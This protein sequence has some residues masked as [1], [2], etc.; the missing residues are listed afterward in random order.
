MLGS[1]ISLDGT[2]RK[3]V[4][5]RGAGTKPL[6]GGSPTGLDGS[7]GGRFLSGGRPSVAVGGLELGVEGA[8][9]GGRPS[10]AVDGLEFGVGAKGAEGAKGGRRPSVA[11]G[12]L[13]LGVGAKGGAR[14]GGGRSGVL[15]DGGAPFGLPRDRGRRPSSALL[16]EVATES[17]LLLL[18]ARRCLRGASWLRKLRFESKLGLDAGIFRFESKLGLDD[19]DELPFG[20]IGPREGVRA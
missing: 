8:K 7:M 15:L 16:N 17:W 14:A 2:R 11:V 18:A 4:L 9:G 10:L 13:E 20:G 3:L 6:S 1:M 19:G 5:I 12:G